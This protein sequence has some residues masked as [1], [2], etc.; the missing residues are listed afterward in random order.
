M[1]RVHIYGGGTFYH[2]RSHLSLCTP[3][4]GSTAKRLRQLL[5]LESELHLTK[6]ADP[7]SNL[8]TNDDVFNHLDKVLD[9]PFVKC[10]ILNAALCDYEGTIGEVESGKYASR[11]ES[12]EGVQNMV[13]T[14]APKII[15]HIK[16]KRPDICVVGFKTTSNE[17]NDSVIH[18]KAKRMNVDLVL[19][20]DVVLRKNFIWTK[21][22]FNSYNDRDDALQTLATMVKS[23]TDSNT[24]IKNIKHYDKHTTFW[25][26]VNNSTS[27]TNAFFTACDILSDYGIE[28]EYINSKWSKYHQN[29]Y[30]VTIKRDDLNIPTKIHR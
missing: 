11:L 2:V 9:D 21:E 18:Y 14:P 25:V 17:A 13:L 26:E 7:T 5:L 30:K 6:M 28:G 1:S 12:R 16:E 23:F 10:V 4:F 27:R 8:V 20:N 24:P 15:S 22:S 3:A 19:A 29:M